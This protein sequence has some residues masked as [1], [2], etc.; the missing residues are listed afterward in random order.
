MQLKIRNGHF[1]Y[2]H[3]AEDTVSV[4]TA[5]PLLAIYDR[6]NTGTSQQ[7]GYTHLA[8][9]WN[10]ND[11]NKY[12]AALQKLLP[13]KE[14]VLI[15]VEIWPGAGKF[16]KEN[17]LNGIASG[18]FDEKISGLAKIISKQKKAVLLRL[19]PDMEVYVD[20]FPWQRQSP[21]E[22]SKAF[23]HFAAVMKKE[24]PAVKMVWS[25]AGYPGSE[26]YWPGNE[27][28]DM[29]AVALKGKSEMMTDNY[30]EEKT[31]QQLIFR[32]LHR[33]RFFDK[34]VLIIGSEKMSKDN[35]EQA[36]FDGAVNYIQQNKDIEYI[37]I[38]A[39]DK[40]VPAETL[41]KDGAFRA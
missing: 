2:K 11:G 8:I 17:I 5:E 26:E 12:E 13:E 4:R 7:Q 32:K 14:P 15:T 29:V 16:S 9:R 24:A 35:F 36:A 33:M 27:W 37:D 18:G 3:F 22:Y 39:A 21:V 19:N 30:P 6:N 31:L 10:T 40:T 23:N 20:L 38:N 1:F 25:P 34:P 28:V 41:R